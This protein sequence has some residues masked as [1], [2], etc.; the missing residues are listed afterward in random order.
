MGTR[1]RPGYTEHLQE[2]NRQM[3]AELETYAGATRTGYHG[4][5]TM[6][7]EEHG[8]RVRGE[9]ETGRWESAGWW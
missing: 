4:A 5:G 7:G 2:A 6:R 3:L 9:Q 8:G 1:P